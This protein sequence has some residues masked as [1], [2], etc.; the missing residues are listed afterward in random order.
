[1]GLILSSTVTVD[2]QV[3]V[4]PA[5]SVTVST[6]VFVPRFVQLKVVLSRLKTGIPQLSELPLSMSA[7]VMVA[8]PAASNWTVMFLHEAMGTTLS[9]TV[10][11]KE[12]VA[13]VLPAASVY[14]QVTVVVPIGNCEPEASPAK[15]VPDNPEPSQLSVKVGA[16]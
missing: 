6:T 5:P 15:R 11:S 16:V 3:A 1:V 4:F 2:V 7:V 14:S 9:V 10:T 8:F 13:G 12:Q